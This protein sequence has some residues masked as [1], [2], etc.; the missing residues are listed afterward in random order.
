MDYI[1]LLRLL[2]HYTIFKLLVLSTQK[3]CSSKIK[4]L[5][6][7]KTCDSFLLDFILPYS[8]MKEQPLPTPSNLLIDFASV[9][10][11]AIVGLPSKIQSAG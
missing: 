5:F 1:F 2:I 4:I 8:A 3:L 10:W 9:L 6:E 11:R 7:E